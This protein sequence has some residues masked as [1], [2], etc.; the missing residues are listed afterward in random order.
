MT[1][2][3]VTSVLWIFALV[4]SL[5][6]VRASRRYE[7]CARQYRDEGEE[8]WERG[9]AAYDAAI[10]KHAEVASM[11]EAHLSVIDALERSTKKP[12]APAPRPM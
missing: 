2:I 7:K 9:Q 3:E 10:A 8:S 12:L 5:F 6:S 4:A 11:I 1:I